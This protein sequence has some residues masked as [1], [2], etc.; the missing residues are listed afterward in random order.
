MTVI[1]LFSGPGGLG[2][3][4][5]EYFDIRTAIDWNRDA[6][7]TYRINHKNT[8]V[9]QK[10]IRD[11]NFSQKDYEGII[12]A[13]A[14]PPCQS[15]SSL[16]LK[17]DLSDKRA[18]LVMETVR[19]IEEIKPEFTLIENVATIP[20]AIKVAVRNRL[21]Q[22]GYHVVSKVVKASDYGSIQ[23]RRRWILTAC[24][25]KSVY[26]Q[27][28]KYNRKAKEILTNEVSEI[29]P[30]KSTLEKI[31]ALPSGKWVSL[32]GQ[33]FKVYYVVDPEKLLPAIVNPTKLRYI[34]P[35]K[36]GYLSINELKQAQGFSKHYRLIGTLSS[37]GQ[38]LANAVPVELGRPFAE[39]ISDLL[40][41]HKKKVSLKQQSKHKTCQVINFL[42]K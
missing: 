9:I 36:S 17:K 34:K 10:D 40:Q 29:K 38:Q 15:F 3:G 6:C 22:L 26:P 31:Q 30:R 24:K 33:K 27:P 25:T 28:V 39:V 23:I 35:D 11:I 13:I 1:D 5:A 20:K 4:F 16:N 18:N 7:K 14:G 32:P 19:V 37:I 12:G 8:E 21:K 42:G 2:T 41:P